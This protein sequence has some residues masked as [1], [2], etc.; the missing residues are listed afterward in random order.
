MLSIAAIDSEELSTS[1]RG[2]ARARPRSDAR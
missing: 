1:A 2:A